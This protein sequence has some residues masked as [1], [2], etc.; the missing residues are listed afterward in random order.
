VLPIELCGG[1]PVDLALS[2]VAAHRWHGFL[3]ERFVDGAWTRVQASTLAVPGWEWLCFCEIMGCLHGI[4]AAKMG[5]GA[6]NMAIRIFRHCFL[7]NW[8]ASACDALWHSLVSPSWMHHCESGRALIFTAYLSRHLCVSRCVFDA[9][10]LDRS[11][12]VAVNV[13]SISVLGSETTGEVHSQ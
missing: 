13:V 9:H 8:V 7:L 3:G 12:P 11:K 4:D 10:W 2:T 1:R 5:M 6:A